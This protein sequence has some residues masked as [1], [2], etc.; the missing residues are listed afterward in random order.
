MDHAPNDS[1]G[2]LDWLGYAAGAIGT[3]LTAVFGYGYTRYTKDRSR[4]VALEHCDQE[5]N[6]R[7]STLAVAVDDLIER[8]D[9]M[10]TTYAET[11]HDIDVKF[12][13]IETHLVWMRRRLGDHGDPFHLAEEGE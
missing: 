8:Q 9:R 12:A 6:S 13:R 3:V 11:R 4:L 1:I 7:V 5:I 2:L 10:V